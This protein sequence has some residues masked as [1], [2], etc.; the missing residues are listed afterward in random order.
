M[1]KILLSLIVL[2]SFSLANAAENTEDYYQD[3]ATYYYLNKDT[4]KMGEY[5]KSLEDNATIT[6][7]KATGAPIA[8][9]LSVV[10]ANNAEKINTW[11][12]SVRFTGETKDTLEEALWISGNGGKIYELFGDRKEYAAERPVNLEQIEVTNPIYIDMMWGAFSASGQAEYVTK[13]IDALNEKKKLSS[14]AEQ[15]KTTRETARWSLKSNITQHE[16]VERTVVAEMA[17]RPE[18]VKSVLKS[19]LNEARKERKTFDKH[20]GDFSAMLAVIAEN[21]TAN[22]TKYTN[23]EIKANSLDKVKRGDKIAI[24]VLFSGMQLD[25]ELNADV[26]Y[27]LKVVAPDGSIYDQLAFGNMKIM[28]EKTA[29]RFGTFYNHDVVVIKF[30]GKDKDGVYKINATTKDN[31]GK[32]SVPLSA[33]IEL[34]Q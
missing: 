24:N 15:D 29:R 8:A 14:D 23:E 9:F 10:F 20:N 1:K 26:S 32:K 30:E 28:K 11:M 17:K 7:H 19:I 2:F 18:P 27:D 12:K 5:I 6:K 3:W 31:I 21:V 13:V 33:K 16:L 4:A 34:I 22:L 25:N